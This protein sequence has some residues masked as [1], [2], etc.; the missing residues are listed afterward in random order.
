MKIAFWTS[1]TKYNFLE[2]LN[3]DFFPNIVKKIDFTEL[4]LKIYSI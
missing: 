1:T 3:S 2:S 4:V